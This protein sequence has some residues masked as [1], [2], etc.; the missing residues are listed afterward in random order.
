MEHWMA[1][2]V[3]EGQKLHSGQI[4][5]LSLISQNDGASQKDLAEEM[6]VRPSSMTE[7]LLRM[8]QTGLITRKQD[9]N[10][11]RV[12]RIF[13]TET[14]KKAAVQSSVTT[15]DL[16]TTMFNCLLPEEQTQM[17]AFVEKISASIE[18][19]VGSDAHDTHHHGHHGQQG[20][21][22]LSFHSKNRDPHSHF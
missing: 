8:E 9:E 12:M 19:L 15:H 6:D 13:L 1:G 11:Q 5:L 17:L 20:H 3:S 21:H 18:T 7:M 16:T 14:G 2:D 4:R 22:H 10:D